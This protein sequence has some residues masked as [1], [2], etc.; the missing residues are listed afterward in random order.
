MMSAAVNALRA[1]R[2]RA[3]T[4]L[5]GAAAAMRTPWPRWRAPS[6]WCPAPRPRRS[7]WPACARA[8]LARRAAPARYARLTAR[9]RAHHR[10]AYRAHRA[11]DAV[12]ASPVALAFMAAAAARWRC[13]FLPLVTAAVYAH[14][15]L[16]AR[17]HDRPLRG[18]AR[19]RRPRAA[20]GPFGPR[21]ARA[22]ARDAMNALLAL[23]SALRLPGL[24]PR[25]R[26][27]PPRWFRL[28]MR[29]A[30]TRLGDGWGWA[31]ARARAG[32]AP[33]PTAAPRS[34]RPDRGRGARRERAARRA[35]ARAPAAAALR[36]RRRT[37]CSATSTPPDRFSFP[38][39][40]TM[41]AFAVGTV[42]ALQFPAAGA[43][44][45]AARG[46]ASAPR[47]WCSGCTTSAT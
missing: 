37:R 1:R 13:R 4:R 28:W 44:A 41:N 35:Q 23:V 46:A 26:L 14:E 40:H 19:A 33:A 8:D 42:L 32:R 20:S 36:V 17:R 38:S 11:A 39:G 5:A 7:S 34:R 6:P 43:R 47:A 27:A 29:G 31:G 18:P 30:A 16:F 25:A 12:A 2:P 3:A 10:R 9:R 24:R 45:R 21:R 15:Q 22:L